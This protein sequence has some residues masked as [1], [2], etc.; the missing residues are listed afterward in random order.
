M[1]WSLRSMG[2]CEE[3]QRQGPS[4]PVMCLHRNSHH[5]N[6][7]IMLA[8][9]KA[10]CFSIFL[11]CFSFSWEVNAISWCFVAK[12]SLPSFRELCQNAFF[13]PHHLWHDVLVGYNCFLTSLGV[14][15]GFVSCRSAF[16]DKITC[17]FSSTI[18][19]PTL[20]SETSAPSFTFHIILSP[21]F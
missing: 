11:L 12:I 8:W 4:H 15:C 9:L 1:L 7:N 18:Y 10:A 17:S 20:N 5:S 19:L 14:S 3:R 2:I 21:S 13:W 16:K 6:P